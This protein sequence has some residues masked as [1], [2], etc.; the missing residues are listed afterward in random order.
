MT[1]ADLPTAPGE[2]GSRIGRV[3]GAL[4]AGDGRQIRHYTTRLG[5]GAEIAYPTARAIRF[6]REPNEYFR[7]RAATGDIRRD[8]RLAGRLD[9]RSGWGT[10]TA[11]ELP[12]IGS[13]V[14]SL[15]ALVDTRRGGGYSESEPF[16]RTV[17]GPDDLR[18]HPA[19]LDFLLSDAILQTAA[20][21]RGSVPVLQT[22]QVWQ[23]APNS[24]TKGSQNFHRDNID[25]RQM[26]FLVHLDYIGME[27]GPFAF[28][29]ADLSARVSGALDDWRR[30][31]GDAEIYAHC[32][33]ADPV[34]DTGPICAATVVD[35]S[36]CFHLDAR[37]KSG[38]RLLAMFNFASYYCPMKSVVPVT[39]AVRPWYRGGDRL[40]RLALGLD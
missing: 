3:L 38:E 37:T 26:K 20:D 23:S 10:F 39:E 25:L 15:N 36:R 19:L 27:Q 18:E 1:K 7:R 30:R 5:L 35:S 12:G 29:P 22:F 4:T 33:P 40:R 31:I 24:T 14:A 13:F 21:Y 17:V 16:R 2:A 9:V 32:S 28:L 34:Y 11:D 8:Q 6:L